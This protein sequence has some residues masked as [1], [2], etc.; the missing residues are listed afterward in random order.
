MNDFIPL[1]RPSIDEREEQAVIETLRSGWITSGPRTA[2]FEEEFAA[3]VGCGR[4]IAVSSG[5]AALHLSLLALDIGP[6][7]EVI[8]SPM[9]WPSLANMT[10]L[11]GARPVFVDI[12]YDTLNIREEL[13]EEAITD[14]TKAIVPV[15][16]AGYPCDMKKIGLI[17]SRHGIPVIEDAAHAAGAEFENRKIGGVSD[18]T[19]F[20][21]HPVKNMTTGE[22]GMITT[23]DDALADK[24]DLLK[25]HGIG[26]PAWQAYG[27][28]A[29]SE[30]GTE[31]PGYKYNFT[32]IL[33]A[34]GVHQLRKLDSFVEAR[35]TLAERYQAA[36][37]D[38]EEIRT[39]RYAAEYQYRHSWCLYS[40]KLE[41]P[42]FT[43]A[44]FLG[45]LKD[46]GI[47]TGVHFVSIH[48]QPFYREKFGYGKE[49]FPAA[50]AVSD[51]VFS[52]P[53]H[54]SLGETEQSRV[55]D[56]IASILSEGKG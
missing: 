17:A 9:S 51:S 32:D 45:K 35:R 40:V 15:H 54:P 41:A 30:Y 7:D 23:N 20:S 2:Q 25:F 46:R 31:M 10:V 33:A 50:A 55:I 29:K 48:V 18:L 13:I 34:M 16:F 21:F 47:G 5:T 44:E 49:D 1:S 19:C 27:A 12:G 36:L 24:I 56:G 52:L 22:G 8:T 4:A 6:G 28:Q 11:L 39:P 14:R 26:R 38:V 42:A 43:R 3:Y 53:L 37:A